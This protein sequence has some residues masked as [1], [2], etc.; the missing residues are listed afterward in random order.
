MQKPRSLAI[1]TLGLACLLLFACQTAGTPK[2]SDGTPKKSQAADGPKASRAADSASPSRTA[3]KSEEKRAASPAQQSDLKGKAA[4]AAKTAKTAKT[5]KT[6]D[7]PRKPL[8]AILKQPITPLRAVL[9]ATLGLILIVVLGAIAAERAGRH[10]K[11]APSPV[12][13]RQ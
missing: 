11:L 3:S 1:L 2:Q 6:V 8:I 9:Y 5:G 10:R 13:A 4:K 7:R 12:D